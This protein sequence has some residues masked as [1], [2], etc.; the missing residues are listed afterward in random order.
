MFWELFIGIIFLSIHFSNI[1]ASVGSRLI[2]LLVDV[3]CLGLK[4]LL[5]KMSMLRENKNVLPLNY[6]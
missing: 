3:K 6:K 1:F 5:M 4:D 2:G